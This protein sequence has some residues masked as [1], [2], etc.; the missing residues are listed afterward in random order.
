[1]VW[2]MIENRPPG[3]GDGMVWY[4]DMVEIAPAV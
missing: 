2:N 4:V 3:G 1:M